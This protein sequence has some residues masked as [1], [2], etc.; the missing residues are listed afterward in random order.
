MPWGMTT[1]TGLAPVSEPGLVRVLR[2]NPPFP[3]IGTLL[4]AWVWSGWRLRIRELPLG[5]SRK[6][7]APTYR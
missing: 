5:L 4:Q 1:P 6:G 7:I 2:V 3:P